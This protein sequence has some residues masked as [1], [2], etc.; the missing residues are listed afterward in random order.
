MRKAINFAAGFL[1]LA[2]LL[3]TAQTA[4]PLDIRLPL[5]SGSVRFAVIGDSGTG[6][7]DQYQTA[8]QMERYREAT[9]FD[10][11]IMLGDN[12]YGGHDPS[13][14]QKKFE[15]PYKALLAAKAKFYASL[16]NHDD[17]QQEIHYQPFNMNG[18]RYYTFSRG[19]VQFFALDSNYMDPKQLTWV[20][21]NL[22]KSGADW[23]IAYCHHPMFSDAKFHGP[24]LDL[25]KS[26]LPLLEKYG[27]NA[28]FSGHEHVYERFKPQD[29]IYF[30]IEGNS[31]QLRYRDL[32]QASDEAAG[33]DTVQDFMLIEIDKNKMYFQ[34]ISRA[35]YTVDSGSAPRQGVSQ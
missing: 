28:V 20:D 4:P 27:V 6:E 22:A 10:F 30:F 14:F 2:A 23:K 33:S 21:Q 8:A 11:V 15:L 31:G 16:G 26:L 35:G 24:D 25:R 12:I 9:K 5:T 7:T 19:D 3:A 1:V 13:D 18:Q 34:T 32:R 17:V 29:G